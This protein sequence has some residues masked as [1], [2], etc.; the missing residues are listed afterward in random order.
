MY[1]RIGIK[2]VLAS[3]RTWPTSTVGTG[4]AIRGGIYISVAWLPILCFVGWVDKSVG[5]HTSGM[6]ILSI[7][8]KCCVL[9]PFYLRGGGFNG[10]M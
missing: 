3:R 9:L 10:V 8:V 5:C 7:V 1:S 6:E 2:P 4:K